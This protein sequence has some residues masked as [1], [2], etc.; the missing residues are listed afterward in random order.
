MAKK[1]T[2][3]W[4]LF[5]AVAVLVGLCGCGRKRA[6]VTTEELLVRYVAHENVDN[7][8]GKATVELSA[9]ALG[10]RA[11]IPVTVD[12]ESADK[13][14]HGTVT[15]D[16]SSLD[17]RNYQMEF[18]GELQDTSIVCYLGKS[19]AKPADWKRWTID[20]TSSI[21]IFTLTNLLSASE[22]TK[23]AKDSDEQVAF[24][25]V[26]PTAKVLETVFELADEP[27]V[28]AG[29]DEQGLLN[30]MKSDKIRVDFTDECLL[31]SF[32]GSALL[33][34]QSAETNN[35]PVKIGLDANAVF[36]DYGAIDPASVRVPEDVK[37][38]AKPATEPIDLIEVLGPDSPFAG[39]I[40]K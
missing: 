40:A 16:L 31:R 27:V 17:T 24:E 33:D 19:G 15:V 22:L 12:I 38:N 39:V 9:S 25:L 5:V 26:V 20:M 10:V 36:D 21:D 28:I 30:A 14:A 29:M 23:I 13:A 35:L 32:S 34:F 6:P 1:T 11:K 18:Y 3:L 2:W 7:F 37:Q 4:V 8:K